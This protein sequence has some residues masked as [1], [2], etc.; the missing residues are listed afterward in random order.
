MS[1][2]A[3]APLRR[4]SA[5]TTLAVGLNGLGG[6]AFWALLAAMHDAARVGEAQRLFTAV[7]VVTYLTSLGLP[8]SVAKFCPDR[9][10]A[11][12]RF[13]RRA[14]AATALSSVFG[15]GVLVAVGRGTPVLDPVAD[16]S[17]AVQ[18]LLLAAA[19]A[20]LSCAVLVEARLMAL[21][22]WGWVV[23]RAGVA[24][25]LRFPLLLLVP[26]LTSGWAFALVA[27]MPACTG[28]V[29]ALALDRVDVGRTAGGRVDPELRRRSV[30]YSTVNYLG[31]LGAQGPQFLVPLAVA[32]AVPSEEFAAFYLCWGATVIV[33][34]VPHLIGQAVLSESSHIGTTLATL[35]RSGRSLSL[36][37]TV[38]LAAG[39]LAGGPL[40]GAVLGP[41]YRAATFL[42]PM[43]V[44]AAVPWAVTST[45]LA[46]ARADADGRRLLVLT[47]SYLL[48][49]VG[50]VSVG[51]LVAGTSGAA[52]GW[53]LGNVACAAA[54]LASRP[55]TGPE[56]FAQADAPAYRLED[57]AL[58]AD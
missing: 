47:M 5:L 10:P 12:V 51:V 48:C 15:A 16:E 23:A 2:S 28:F 4:A 36:G 30:R 27:G 31:L 43:L 24:V 21:R 55:A 41:E 17:A 20:G 25:L 40:I 34:A 57:L 45:A 38:L 6:F 1:S 22:Q 32:M 44:L 39:A 37:I 35:G 33:F 13:F 53:L 52:V 19:A 49:A 14:V 8:V 9:S 29:G 7:L 11:A 46:V 18:F 50:G 56:R 3:T 54:T 26:T 42:L 58:A